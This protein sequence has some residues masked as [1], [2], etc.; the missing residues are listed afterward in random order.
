MAGV[1]LDAMRSSNINRFNEDYHIAIALNLQDRRV[2]A[3]CDA[4]I[5]CGIS[6]APCSQPHDIAHEFRLR[7]DQAHG[8]AEQMPPQQHTRNTRTNLPIFITVSWDR[9]YA[10]R[11]PSQ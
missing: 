4:N 6:I 5:M 11:P 1:S 3:N 9:I 8:L 2:R 10:S 7:R